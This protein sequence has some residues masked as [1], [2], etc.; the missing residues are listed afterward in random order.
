MR[1]NIIIDTIMKRRNIYNKNNILKRRS[2]IDVLADITKRRKNIID[3]PIGIIMK[4]RRSIQHNNSNSNMKRRK[5]IIDAL[6]D[7]II[8]KKRRNTIIHYKII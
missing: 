6:A 7:V 8:I 4:R 2:I 5:N 3:A 1:K